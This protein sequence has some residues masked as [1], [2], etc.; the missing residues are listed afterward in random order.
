VKLEFKL[1]K[2]YQVAVVSYYEKENGVNYHHVILVTRCKQ[3]KNILEIHVMS[4]SER[5]EYLSFLG[6]VTLDYP[7]LTIIGC[8]SSYGLGALYLLD[9]YVAK[10]WDSIVEQLELRGDR[11]E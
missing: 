9:K 2:W 8:N 7:S 11:D 4:A 6:T 5:D 10:V 1:G 3:M